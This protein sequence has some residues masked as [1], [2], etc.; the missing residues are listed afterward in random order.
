MTHPFHA[1]E[2]IALEINSYLKATAESSRLVATIGPF[3]ASADPTSA[4]RYRNYALPNDF[5]SPSLEEIA[6][7]ITWYRSR[8]RIP[9]LEYMTAAAPIVEISLIRAGFE[10]E[11]R[12]PVMVPG[13]NPIISSKPVSGIEIV[14]VGDHSGLSEAAAVQNNAYGEATPT[15]EDIKRL[16]RNVGMGG[17][18]FLARDQA[19]RRPV[20]AGLYSPPK[21]GITELAGVGVIEGYRRRGIACDLT[22]RLVQKAFQAGVSTP[23]LMAGGQ[24][25]VSMYSRVGFVCFSEVLH[26]SLPGKAAFEL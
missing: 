20:G 1:Q 2:T 14:E 21:K 9:R 18:V 12:L 19:T 23:F 5:A 25:E 15:E 7:L 26:I 13:A 8:G 6:E 17:A 10:V 24:N 16:L 4:N 11:G 22:T 3:L